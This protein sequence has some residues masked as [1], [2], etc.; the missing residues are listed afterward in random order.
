MAISISISLFLLLGL[1]AFF[2]FKNYKAHQ[3]IEFLT[4]ILKNKN[5]ET[6]E[7]NNFKDAFLINT[8]HELQTPLNGI[9]GISES[10]LKGNSGKLSDETA[11]NIQLIKSSS[12]RLS[13]LIGDILD[14]AKLKQNELRVNLKPVA[15]KEIIDI[16]F[17]FFKEQAKNKNIDLR[18]ELSDQIPLV[19]ADENRLQQIF[20]NLIGN[21]IKFTE[22]GN[23]LIRAQK[24]N[25][26]LCIKI[27][28]T[29]IGI[30]DDKL[31]SIFQS[32]KQVDPMSTKA[33][34]GTGL[35]LSITRQLITLQNGKISVES[36]LGQ[37]STF[38]LLIPL[39]Q[40]LNTNKQSEDYEDDLNVV[41]QNYPNVSVISPPKL[42]DKNVVGI[43]REI[44]I[45]D[46][47]PINLQVASNHLVPEHYDVTTAE[48]GSDAL[49]IISV[50]NP[51][52]LILLDIMMPGIDGFEV[53]K[54]IRA[55]YSPSQLPIIILS[56]KNSVSDL[57]QAFKLGVNDYLTKPFT[58]EELLV[59]VK[60]Q[61][62]LKEAYETLLENTKLR[63]ELESRRQT[64]LELRR[65]QYKLSKIL[66]HIEEALIGVNEHLEIS[67]CNKRFGSII[68][69]NSQSLLGQSFEVLFHDGSL[70][71]MNERLKKI[72]FIEDELNEYEV[73]Q[74]N[75]KHLDGTML[76]KN[77]AWT[78]IDFEDEKMILL[79]VSDD[80][81]AKNNLND[82]S[83]SELYEQ[84]ELLKKMDVELIKAQLKE[85]SQW[86]LSTII[87]DDHMETSERQ[88]V[89]DLL[90][91]NSQEERA[92]GQK[93]ETIRILLVE[94][95]NLTIDYWVTETNTTKIDLARN[96]GIWK[97]YTNRDGW[98]RAQTMDKYLEPETLPKNPRRKLVVQTAEF[99]LANCE[100][101]TSHRENLELSL[102]RLKTII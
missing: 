4:E 76:T 100:K 42:V 71:L 86:D 64:E 89:A 90:I 15:I 32:Y 63:N 25:D 57:V 88:K 93:Q 98:E 18:H 24:Q 43:N 13:N 12:L 74:L 101:A 66:D 87:L 28:D 3:E 97:V 85:S 21:A 6:N 95:M 9:I 81:S 83:L 44:L 92:E 48:C 54:K 65:I 91:S 59:R 41:Q 27:K 78:L 79:I 20:Y 16:V 17:L 40:E 82:I 102:M 47:E 49:N 46:D 7:I 67:F 73:N 30:P 45:V 29:G 19:M 75:F 31:E 33:T 55:E 53:C 35:G 11:E 39:S 8:S 37:G 60:N 22:A 23:I 80:D 99:V 36:V 10:L 5:E 69:Y 70:S 56:V 62:L 1:S 68:G 96:S 34:V 14:L 84:D 72:M 26:F 94:I 2:V 51:P 61:L 52:D 50:R 58:G 38:T 77:V